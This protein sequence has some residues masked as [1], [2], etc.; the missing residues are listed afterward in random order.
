MFLEIASLEIAWHTVLHVAHPHV[1]TPNSKSLKL[2][3][4]S[5][6]VTATRV[7]KR[8]YPNEKELP[9]SHVEYRFA[10][11]CSA[12]RGDGVTQSVYCWCMM[13]FWRIL[14]NFLFVT[15]LFYSINATSLENQGLTR[16][17]SFGFVVNLH[18]LTF[19]AA[20]VNGIIE[21]LPFFQ[22]RYPVSH[23]ST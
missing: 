13:T 6:H 14:R 22:A 21:N 17:V 3:K 19:V 2:W 10:S 11:T 12:Y 8:K 23:L 15:Q 4:F 20:E 16:F 18:S 1:L 7:V 5:Q 9:E